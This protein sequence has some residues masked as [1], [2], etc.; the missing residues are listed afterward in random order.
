MKIGDK[1]IEHG[2]EFVCVER[3]D[4]RG[5][6]YL[7]WSPDGDSNVREWISNWES[8]PNNAGLLPDSSLF[9]ARMLQRN[10]I[11]ASKM[12]FSREERCIH[13]KKS[14]SWKSL[15]EID[16]F[17][18]T[19]SF[20]IYVQ[21]LPETKRHKLGWLGG[22]FYWCHKLFYFK[23]VP[24]FG[25][26]RK[27]WN[28]L[29]LKKYN[30]EI[31]KFVNDNRFHSDYRRIN[32]AVYNKDLESAYSMSVACDSYYQGDEGVLSD[33]LMNNEE[34]AAYFYNFSD[35]PPTLPSDQ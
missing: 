1:I 20:T 18:D 21:D 10:N 19:S 14:I 7:V 30:E 3:K 4:E 2:I 27:K 11:K 12:N 8:N 35:D 15:D 22:F 13:K 29:F 28:N 16:V 26:A 33:L 17:G 9:V 6:A 24:K 23:F 31:S 5:N 34:I 32:E 25:W